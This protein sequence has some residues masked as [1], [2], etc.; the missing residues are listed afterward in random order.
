MAAKA[1]QTEAEARIEL[2]QMRQEEKTASEDG[3]STG[4]KSSVYDQN[5]QKTRNAGGIAL[6]LIV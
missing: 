5:F 1:T 3:E 4:Q 2:A 6:D